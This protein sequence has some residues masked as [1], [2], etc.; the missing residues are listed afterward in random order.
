MG[1]MFSFTFSSFPV[2]V[3]G[4]H[5]LRDENLL[6][7][8]T[9]SY[10]GASLKSQQE[11]LKLTR[12]YFIYEKE[13]ETYEPISIL[14]CVNSFRIPSMLEHSVIKGLGLSV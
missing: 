6:F 5:R 9:G 11:R 2:V 7:S 4:H 14:A 12:L 3:G 10:L 13:R 1:L 8:R